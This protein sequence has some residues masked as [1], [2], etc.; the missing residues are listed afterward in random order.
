MT[1]DFEQSATIPATPTDVYDAWLSAD[2]HTAMTGGEATVDPVVGGQFT[3]W[4]GYITG[5]NLALEPHHRILQ[6][7]RTSEFT[8]ADED[9]TIEV[10]LDPVG[11]GTLL[12]L[13]HRNVPSDHHGYEDGGWQSQYFDPMIE[14]FSR[15]A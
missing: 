15:R 1:Y 4:D 13:N 3:A 8:P 7:W 5:R 10:T 12:R 9:S 14:Y 2:A 6:S 11:G